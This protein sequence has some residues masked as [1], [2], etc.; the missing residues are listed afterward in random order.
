[1]LLLPPSLLR[2][3]LRRPE[4]YSTDHREC[5]AECIYNIPLPA[6]RNSYTTAKPYARW[7]NLDAGSAEE[8]LKLCWRRYAERKYHEQLEECVLVPQAECEIQYLLLK[9]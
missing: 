6:T 3:R 5:F 9:L 7:H 1:M 4:T 2:V 8:A